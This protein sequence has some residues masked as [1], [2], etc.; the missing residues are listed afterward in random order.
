MPLLELVQSTTHWLVTPFGMG[1]QAYLADI[2]N[3]AA[4]YSSYLHG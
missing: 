2:K 4:D 3:L 1:K